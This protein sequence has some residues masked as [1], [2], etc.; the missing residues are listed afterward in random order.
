MA[1]RA[2]SSEILPRDATG[3]VIPLET[4]VLY[5]LDGLGI[6]VDAFVY[7]NG[8]WYVN[9]HADRSNFTARCNMLLLESPEPADSW[10]ALLGDLDAL[11]GLCAERNCEDCGWS[12][13]RDVSCE[14]VEDV[15]RE[16][17]RRIRAL[18]GEGA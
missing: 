15:T 8:K 6:N 4:N 1:P 12:H 10:E 13:A 17:A 14:S 11:S 18:R 2:S 3:R 9:Y 5:R 7:R 16:T